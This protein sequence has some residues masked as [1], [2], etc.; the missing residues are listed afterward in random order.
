MK[1]FLSW[2][3]ERSKVAAQILRQWLPEVIQSLE[4][5]MSA[6]DIN[7]G[8]R[9]NSELT[10]KLAETRCGI[11]CL[12]EDNQLAPWVHFEAGS[13]SK[14]IEKT[15][16]IPYLIDLEPADINAGPLTQFQAKRSNKAETWELV[17]TLN[18]ALDKPL[19]EAQLE[20]GFE[21][22]WNE[23]ETK[24]KDLPEPTS[25]Q[26]KRSEGDKLTE[27]LEVV[28]TLQRAMT[29]DITPRLESLTNRSRNR[30]SSP[31]PER[32]STTASKIVPEAVE[33]PGDSKTRDSIINALREQRSLQTV[34]DIVSQFRKNSESYVIAVIKSMI[35]DGIITCSEPFTVLSLISL[36]EDKDKSSQ[37]E[38]SPFTNRKPIL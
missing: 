5:W 16:V 27:V 30:L 18:G 14:T 20:R 28:R 6:A 21:R 8:A 15:Y 12:T 3:G 29:D 13:L 32:R 4:P 37:R 33:I 36:V 35:E 19:A 2:S 38:F 7:A 23:L 11:I 25:H 10:N 24:L 34:D 26:E 9:W 17:R 31:E 22:C 1:V